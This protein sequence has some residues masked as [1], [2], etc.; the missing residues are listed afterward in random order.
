MKHYWHDID[1]SEIDTPALIIDKDKVL[2]N[3]ELAISY[4][5]GTNHL[6]PHVKTHK[7]LEV[8][9]LQMAAGIS[10]FKCATIAE[11][12]MLGLAGAAD[13]LMAYPVQGPK[14]DCVLKLVSSYPLTFL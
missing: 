11:A 5:G 10:K 14:I 13:V 9:K 6:R 8:V 3:I 4:A 7:M 1:L 12:E 2:G